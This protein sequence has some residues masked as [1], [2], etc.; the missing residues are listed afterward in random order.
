MAELFRCEGFFFTDWATQ[1]LDVVQN[2]SIPL[3]VNSDFLEFDAANGAEE[4]AGFQF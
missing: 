3:H 2:S 4:S 1:D